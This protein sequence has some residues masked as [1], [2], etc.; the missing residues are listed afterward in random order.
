M[1]ENYREIMENEIGKGIC[2][3][4]NNNFPKIMV[5]HLDGNHQNNQKDNLVVLCS[6]CHALVH[7]GFSK[8]KVLDPQTKERILYLRKFLLLKFYKYSMKYAEDRIKYER[9]LSSNWGNLKRCAICKSLTNLRLYAPFFITRFD[10]ENKKGIGIIICKEC[11][12]IN[13]NVKNLKPCIQHI[14]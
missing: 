2:V 14:H 6:L 11:S 1:K 3:C 8:K 7:R 13:E 10:K 5:H 12:K 9:A 4:C